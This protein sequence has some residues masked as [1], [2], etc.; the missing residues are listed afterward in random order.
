M[1]RNRAYGRR[2][3]AGKSTSQWAC[4]GRRGLALVAPFQSPWQSAPTTMWDRIP[5]APWWSRRGRGTSAPRHPLGLRQSSP[6]AVRP[7]PPAVAAMLRGRP[8]ACP[9]VPLFFK[10]V[11]AALSVIAFLAIPSTAIMP[12][13]YVCVFMTNQAMRLISTPASR[14]F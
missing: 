12:S 4:P 1:T 5:V 3:H 9:S 10:T 2:I 8:R 7:I 14:I 13:V 11:F 6:R